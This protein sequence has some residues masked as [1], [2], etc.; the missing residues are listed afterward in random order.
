MLY[1]TNMTSDSKN[2]KTASKLD[3]L[4]GNKMNQ[5]RLARGVTRH[6]LAEK[7]GVTHQQLQKYEKGINRITASRLADIAHA[8][9]VDVTYFFEDDLLPLDDEHIERQRMCIELMRDFARIKRPDQQEAIRRLV[10]VLVD[11]AGA[12]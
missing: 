11:E 10:K 8:L 2:V 1:M 3:A 4:I 7:V 6:Q 5:L 12:A 9:G